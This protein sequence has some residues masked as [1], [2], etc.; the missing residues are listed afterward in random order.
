MPRGRVL[1]NKEIWRTNA[2]PYRY[3][4]FPDIFGVPKE[5]LPR[6]I[7]GSSSVPSQR[8]LYEITS[9]DIE[10]LLSLCS[11][12]LRTLPPHPE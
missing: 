2:R 7:D 9:N 6:K 3:S 4:T 10:K 11:K 12:L 8:A 5:S 1:A